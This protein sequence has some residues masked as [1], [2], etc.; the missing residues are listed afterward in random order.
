[1][2]ENDTP[3][4]KDPQ[5]LEGMPSALAFAAHIVLDLNGCKPPP[6]LSGRP[7]EPRGIPEPDRI[8]G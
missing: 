6:G 5:D 8:G 7:P 4:D 3:L 1:M 2:S